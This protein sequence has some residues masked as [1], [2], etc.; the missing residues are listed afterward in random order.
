MHGN[1]INNKI[2][3]HNQKMKHYLSEH[4]HLH[5]SVSNLALFIDEAFTK[6][7]TRGLAT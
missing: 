4:M 5:E 3:S 7:Q 1:N 6:T 2:E